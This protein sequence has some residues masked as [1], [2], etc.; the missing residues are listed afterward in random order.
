MA[1]V[2][3]QC[4]GP[5]DGGPDNP[6]YLPAGFLLQERYRIGRVLG[7]GGFGIVY[8]AWDTNLDVK[9]AVKEFLP[10]EYAA[11]GADHHT[12]LPYS[13]AAGDEFALG[14]GKFLAEAKALA[15][16]QDHPGIVRV[17]ESFRAHQ[18]AYMVMQY[19]DGMSMKDYLKRQPGGRIPYA[20]AVRILTPVLD[21]LREVHAAGL[22][23]R[24]ISPDNIF[25]TR[26]KQI[27]L[28]DFGAARYAIGEH[29]K[30]LTS[31]LKHGYA[32][33]EQYSTKGNQGP[34][35]DVY[36]V[37]ATIYRCITGSVPPDA[38]E[39][40][41]GDTLRSPRQF[42]VEIPPS[43]EAALLKG[44]ALKVPQRF[45]TI[46]QFQKALT[47]PEPPLLQP[48]ATSPQERPPSPGS[49]AVAGGKTRS[50]SPGDDR[51][52]RP[53]P[54]ANP[55]TVRDY[56]GDERNYRL[57]TLKIA[58]G[59]FVLLVIASLALKQESTGPAAPAPTAADATRPAPAG[60]VRPDGAPVVRTVGIAPVPAASR[61]VDSGPWRYLQSDTA[62]EVY[63]SPDSL[64][65]L[66]DGLVEVAAD[67]KQ[68]DQ[69]RQDIQLLR[70]NCPQKKYLV[71]AWE[72]YRGETLVAAGRHQEPPSRDFPADSPEL[73]LQQTVC[74]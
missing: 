12:V 72:E 57:L 23:H 58:G 1:P 48:D 44:L 38:M 19:L 4:G 16:F 30:S 65:V 52:A 49:T 32:P 53:R 73:T 56:G 6:L 69:D 41:Q 13:G 40:L 24:D 7:V 45:E 14:I 62:K 63:Y 37:A 43:A 55:T 21:A 64:K 66:P 70:V 74:R 54:G 26:Q 68:L 42:D 20:T 59:I 10:K 36:A 27:K 60:S 15:R 9:V 25:I 47:P 67:L 28:L 31:V 61:S 50:L 29:S 22:V 39:R 33:V 46:E 11:R 71:I 5:T 34:W 3:P 51:P 35:S 8:L 17:H 18:T 2:C